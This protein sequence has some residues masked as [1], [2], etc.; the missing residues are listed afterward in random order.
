[1]DRLEEKFRKMGQSYECVIAAA[2]EA[3]RINAIRVHGGESSDAK[4]TTE[5]MQKLLDGDFQWGIVDPVVAAVPAA[6][7]EFVETP[8]ED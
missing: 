4:V 7:E 6:A 1:M 8:V 5:A 2:L 3:R